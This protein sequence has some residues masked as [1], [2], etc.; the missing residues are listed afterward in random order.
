[1][2]HTLLKPKPRSWRQ[3]N[4]MSYSPCFG[5]EEFREVRGQRVPGSSTATF[6]ELLHSRDALPP[7]GGV[8]FGCNQ[9]G[10]G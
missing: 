9:Q 4:L 6:R 8:C 3:R 10:G 1:L 5:E 2:Y 7:E